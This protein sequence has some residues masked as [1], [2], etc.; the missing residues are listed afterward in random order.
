MIREAMVI[1]SIYNKSSKL[2]IISKANFNY[3]S[4]VDYNENNICI[5]KNTEF[6]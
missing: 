5:T 6:D 3:F 2:H 1:F 4:I